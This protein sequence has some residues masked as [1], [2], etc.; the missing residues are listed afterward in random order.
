MDIASLLKSA[1]KSVTAPNPHSPPD[2]IREKLEKKGYSFAYDVVG[3]FGY[4]TPV[5]QVIAPG[6]EIIDWYRGEDRASRQYR[7]DFNQALAEREPPGP[8]LLKK[9]WDAVTAPDP[10]YPARE[11][12]ET[13][14]AKGYKFDFTIV[15]GCGMM[16]AKGYVTSADGKRIDYYR[17]DEPASE[18][19]REDYRLAQQACAKPVPGPK[20]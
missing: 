20:L 9:I 3:Q 19:Y 10:H 16:V 7:E 1:W 12:R 15:G 11:V 18:K 13:L 17:G 6:G 8:S 14:E 2:D 5:Q 4:L